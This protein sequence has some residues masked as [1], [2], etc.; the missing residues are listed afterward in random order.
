MQCLG[1]IPTTASLCAMVHEIQHP[2]CDSSDIAFDYEP[3]LNV[4]LSVTLLCSCL[5]T[6]MQESDLELRNV[7]GLTVISG[8]TLSKLI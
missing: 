4:T 5:S 3:D 1:S 7:A 6:L 2:V 8:I